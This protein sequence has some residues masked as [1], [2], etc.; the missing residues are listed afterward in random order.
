MEQVATIPENFITVFNTMASDLNLPTPWPKPAGYVPP[1]AD[2][3]ILIWGA[4]SSVGQQ[5]LQVLRYYGYKHLL[6]TASSAHH[7]Y[8]KN[9][10][11]SAVVDYKDPNVAEL[12]LSAAVQIRGDKQPA[13]PMVIDCIGSQ[14]GSLR[15]I[16]QIAQ[17]GT[18][19][20]IM[21]PVILKHASADQTPEYSME[22]ESAAPWMD[23][24]EPKGVRTHFVWRVGAPAPKSE[25]PAN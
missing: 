14:E 2:E 23:G 15:A 8:L 13:V 1:R 12:L 25:T 11:A 6:A 17:R 19:V 9:I 3:P 4:A 21:L 24:V 18:T 7:D 22:V 20:A 5:A 16:A 10:G